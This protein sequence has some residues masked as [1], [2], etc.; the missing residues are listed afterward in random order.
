M[1]N[2][3]LPF[4]NALSVGKKLKFIGLASA[5]I[6]GT[7][8]ISM[9][10]A[11]QYISEKKSTVKEST[12]FANI[13]AGNIAQSITSG[14]VLAISNTLA[15]VEYN[16]KIHQTFALDNSWKLLGAFHKGNDFVR[17]RKIIPLIKEYKNLWHDGYFYSVVPILDDETQ[18]GHLVVVA[19]LDDFYTR[20]MQ[21]VFVIIFIFLIAIW[22]TAKFRESLQKSILEPIATLDAIT[23]EIIKTKN[24]EHDIPIFN[25]DEIGELAKN[26]KYMLSELNEYHHELNRQKNAFSY[27]ANYDSLTNLPNRAL[28]N[29]RLKQSI[30]KSSRYS[31]KFALFFIDLD[32]FK[33][34]NDTF[35]HEYGDKLLI[36]VAA[37][38][39]SILREGD[40]LARLGGDEFIVIMNNLKEFHSASVLAQKIIDILEVPLEV[41]GEELFISCSVGI[42][43]YPQD[44]RDE[45]ELL[46]FADIAMYRSKSDGRATYHFYVEEMTKEVLLRAKMQSRIRKALEE[47]EFIVYY[48]PQYNI[49]TDKIVGLEALVRW[50]D[51]EKGLI[52]PGKFIPFAEELGMVVAINRQ[53]MHKTMLQAKAWH[54]EGLYFGRLSIN[55]SIEQIEDKNFIGLVQSLLYNTKCSPNWITLELTEGQIMKDPKTA[56][57][58]L[59]QLNSLGILIAIDDFGT[60]YSSL[61]YLKHLPISELKIDRSFIMDIPEDEDDMAIVDSI[62]A[63]SKSLKLNLV[64]EGV[65]TEEQKEFLISK[66]CYIVQGYLY[67]RPMPA[68]EV[69]KLLGSYLEYTPV[70]LA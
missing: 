11:F 56:I 40:T 21:Y 16:N 53:V 52:L 1:F 67:A 6:A 38:L 36:K 48:Q 46:K 14:D 51:P 8:V 58:I 54:N 66:E 59:E 65:E 60:G 15:S 62:I 23:T 55:I 70:N 47:R 34:I 4:Y 13:L 22:I 64:A 19:S 30:Y 49:K 27:Q 28:F 20:M 50:Q 24:L 57:A 61:S 32:K 2:M 68:E 7:I 17:Q 26:F 43:L 69:S 45:R 10:F 12:V 42:S 9:L 35:G 5:L 18:I 31:E 44:S 3:I 33:D 29:D 63:I 37:R 25:S 39:N 41:E